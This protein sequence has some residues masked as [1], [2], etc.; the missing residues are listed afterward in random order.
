MQH[1]WSEIQRTHCWLGVTSQPHIHTQNRGKINNLKH[2]P[3]E[4]TVLLKY[5]QH[6]WALHLVC[7]KW[8]KWPGLSHS[9]AEKCTIEK[10]LLVNGAGECWMGSFSALHV[11]F[12]LNCL[13][14]KVDLSVFENSR[15]TLQV[16]TETLGG[17]I[18][19][20]RHHIVYSLM[21]RSQ[22]SLLHHFK[23]VK[24]M[25]ENPWS[26]LINESVS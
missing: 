18:T 25:Q 1:C 19:K 14:M 24:Q 9:S 26:D 8:L 6:A 7:F 12:I 22:Q 13:S 2:S 21:T 5:T 16:C 4:I 3:D 20:A 17:L 10:W 23:V 11:S 15:V